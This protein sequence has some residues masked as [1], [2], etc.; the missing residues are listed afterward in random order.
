M[1]TAFLWISLFFPRMTLMICYFMEVIPHNST[2][3]LLDIIVSILAPRILIA[4][5]A[6]ENG[7]PF[8]CFVFVLFSFLSE[9]AIGL[10]ASRKL[11]EPRKPRSP[12]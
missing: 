2:P 11:R 1:T 8:W 12:Y 6:A 10:R 5:W 4:A 3:L 9:P 7:H